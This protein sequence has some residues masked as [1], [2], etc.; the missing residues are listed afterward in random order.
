[1]P[2]NMNRF[3]I[4]VV[5]IAGWL[6]GSMAFAQEPVDFTR[7]VRP[8]LS[9]HC[10]RCHGPDSARRQADLR[11]DTQAGL[12]EQVVTPSN[13]DE[14]ELYRRV[15]SVDPDVRMPPPESKLA[16]DDQQI[17]L[18]KRW[19]DEGAARAPHWSYSPIRR[20]APPD[21][22]SAKTRNAVDRFVLQRLQL[23]GWDLANAESPEK[24][25]RRVTFDLTGLPPTVEQV[26]AFLADSSDAAYEAVVDRLLHDPA[27][28]ERMAW[29]WLDAARYADT[30]G[31]QGD[32]E[33]TMW[34]W[35]DWVIDAFNRNMPF[36]RFTIEQIAGDLLPDATP[37]TQIATGFFRNYMINGEGGRIPEE[38]R[39][40]Y[41]FDQTET[42]GTIWLGTTL[43][44]CRCHDHKF[45]PI[46]TREYYQLSA[47][48]DQTPVDG[49]GGDP[50]TPPI[51]EVPSDLQRR[52]LERLTDQIAEFDRQIDAR[53][54]ELGSQPPPEMINLANS[55]SAE[56]WS[57]LDPLEYKAQY[58]TLQRLDDRSLLAGGVNPD[59]DQY[60]L[61]FAI[62]LPRLTAIRLEALRH[63]S[64]TGGGLARS[65]SGNFV[66]TDIAIELLTPG[67]FEP[68]PL[69]IA[70]AQAT[71]EQPGFAVTNAFDDDP[72]S[73]WAVWPGR[74]VEND[75]AAAFVLAE[76]RAIEEGSRLRIT[77]KH[78]SSHAKHNLGHFRLS[79]TSSASPELPPIVDEFLKE[80]FATPATQR[81]EKQFE[82]V[83]KYLRESDEKLI[84]WVRQRDEAKAHLLTLNAAIPRVMVLADR[85]EKRATYILAKGSYQ[86]HGDQV[87]P[88]FPQAIGLNDLPSNNRLDLANWIVDRR[89]PLTARVTV[90]RLWQ[91]LFG[92]GLV[93][94][95]EDFGVQGESPIHREL[96]DWL[97][98]EF[99][100]SGWDVK[101]LLKTI[102][103]SATYRQSSAVDPAQYEEDP[104]NRLLGRGPRRRLPSWAIRDQALAVSGLL[105]RRIGGPSVKPYQP[106]GVWEEATFGTQSYQQG[107]GD[108][109]YR[110]SL[111]T[112]W[113]RIIAPTMFFDVASRQTCT[114]KTTQTNTPLHALTTLNDMTY[115][116]AARVMAERVLKFSHDPQAR[117]E[118][119]F[120]LATS[121]KPNDREQKILLDRVDSE[122]QRYGADS[123]AARSLLDQGEYVGDASLP[124]AEHAAWTSVCLLL[125]NLD[126][127]LNN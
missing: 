44:C 63:E 96:L 19:I 33:R 117:V 26:D 86:A 81:N 62:G 22:S 67:N 90:N 101:H 49:S 119:A 25:L 102:V 30:N 108:D 27:Y 15:S 73:G 75:Q 70:S 95:V 11:L 74:L 32:G 12:F 99:I 29:D 79:A 127:T 37:Q 10:F 112:Y 21:L 17:A 41:V 38:N 66:L 97:A 39:I 85:P 68:K 46:T 24:L 87:E 106:A 114:V 23:T 65:D 64:M 125:L 83:D 4:A 53:Q 42:L 104:D 2:G 13:A 59:N 98:A 43:T 110:R 34:P 107:H 116:E 5:L 47:F 113:K 105:V 109:L 77:L 7:D 100:D 80:A 93:K 8:I 120:R 56:Q 14:S 51:V 16:L 89:N 9:D 71:Y 76:P 126:E 3:L 48:F 103:M 36:D 122:L 121:R 91:M 60:A 57:P 124:V 94:T 82:V 35:R 6:P 18:L 69:K 78:D 61:T 55:Q 115:V 111:Y 52:D 40:D 84:Q 88:G 58:A 50:Q 31:F 72:T 28:G 20:P 92:V 118:F 45:D 1:M 54:S 123:R